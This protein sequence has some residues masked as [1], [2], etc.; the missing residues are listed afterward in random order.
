M[1]MKKSHYH[2]II[3][4][5]AFAC[6]VLLNSCSSTHIASSWRDP[7]KHIHPTDWKKVLVMAL[8]TNETNRRSA[9][10]EMAKY[11]D[12]KGITSYSYLDENFNAK[13]EQA[14]R[15]KIKKDSFDAAITMRLI[16]VDKEKVYTPQQY[17]MY[18]MYYNDFITY[19][20]RNWMYYNI[21]G[22][23]TITKKFIIETIIYSIKDDKI[24]WSGITETYDP[25]GVKRLTNE[26]ARTLRNKMQQEGFIEK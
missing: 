16:D 5:T 14:L 6:T 26:I 10:D 22:Y 1:I 4:F 7:D 2:R 8:L 24:I 18:P 19:Y 20:Y 17:Y 25:K 3:L 12:G 13:D 15:S 23:Y 11:L 21:P 9:E